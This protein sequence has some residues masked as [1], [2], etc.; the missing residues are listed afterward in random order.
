M[1]ALAVL[2]VI[3][4]HYIVSTPFVGDLRV[5]LPAFESAL[6]MGWCGVDF[7]FV[8]SGFLIGGI[9]IDRRNSS[10]L[11]QVFF[12]R[13][14]LR[15][16]PAYYLLLLILVFVPATAWTSKAQ[17]VPLW[18]F[19]LFIQNFFTSF[20]L[21]AGGPFGPLWSIAIEEQF[22]LL[23]P[24]IARFVSRRAAKILLAAAIFLPPILRSVMATDWSPIKMSG[25][26]FTP[27]RVDGLALGV[28]GAWLVRTPVALERLKRARQLH[29]VALV[30]LGFGAVALSQFTRFKG[31]VRVQ[32]TIGITY[33]SVWFLAVLLYAVIHAADSRT[34]RV[35][36]FP[37]LCSAGRV[38]YSLYL[39]HIPALLLVLHWGVRSPLF[40]LSAAA[41][42]LGVC[43]WASWRWFE[44]PLI[45]NG[46]RRRY[47][48]P[49]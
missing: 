36:R 46:K 19:F 15:I 12:T 37:A 3:Q 18:A 5:R 39:F 33:L 30:L 13:R 34:A 42:V 9:L 44:S 20:G 1:R 2:A 49:A 6:S 14:A 38:S 10:N 31:G 4:L 16:L 17:E 21:R 47:D 11:F 32:T 48:P 41:L 28:A 23:A 45:A 25:W 29:R 24:G 22:Y 40:V 7:F 43:A 8:I 35:L 27:T 26:D